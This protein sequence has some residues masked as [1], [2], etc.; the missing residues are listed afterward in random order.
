MNVEHFRDYCMAK[1]G[2]TGHF[3]FDNDTLVFKV[4]GKMFALA[5]LARWE[6]GEGFIN[7]KCNPQYAQDLRAEYESI[8]PGYHMHKKQWNSVYIQTGEL[9]LELI[10]KLIDH[11]YDLVVEGLPKK[12]REQL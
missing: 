4:L 7:L 2:V 12:I 11:S 8:K 6:R 1:K 5:S 10:L 3:P 9:K